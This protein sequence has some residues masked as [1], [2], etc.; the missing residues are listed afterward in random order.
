MFVLLR[1]ELTVSGSKAINGL[2]DLV[3]EI[4]WITLDGL[5]LVEIGGWF[6]RRSWV[7]AYAM[8]ICEAAVEGCFSPLGSRSA[9]CRVYRD[10][11]SC[12]D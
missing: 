6:L 3:C 4:V 9:A 12:L 8:F 5:Y 1:R 10:L 7:D 2:W 11:G